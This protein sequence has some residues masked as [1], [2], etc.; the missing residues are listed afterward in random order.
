LLYS[1]ALISGLKRKRQ[2]AMYRDQSVLMLMAHGFDPKAPHWIA[3]MG[4]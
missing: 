4:L 3:D 1:C 2:I